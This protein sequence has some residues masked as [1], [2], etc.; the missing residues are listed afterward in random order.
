MKRLCMGAAH[1]LRDQKVSDAVSEW[2]LW[3]DCVKRLCVDAPHALRDQKVGD[4][5][6]K[7]PRSTLKSALG[8]LR[9]CAP[10]EGQQGVVQCWLRA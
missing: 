3:G 9:A 4:A 5:V 8:G 1:A 6:Q 2:R 7:R 10:A